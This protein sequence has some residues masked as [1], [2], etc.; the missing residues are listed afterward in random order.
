MFVRCN[1]SHLTLRRDKRRTPGEGSQGRIGAKVIVLDLESLWGAWV[2][3]SPESTPIA[4]SSSPDPVPMPLPLTSAT[5]DKAARVML[6]GVFGWK[7]SESA[8]IVFRLPKPDTR[9]AL[10]QLRAWMITDAIPVEGVDGACRRQGRGL[11]E[12]LSYE[13]PSNQ[14]LLVESMSDAAAGESLAAQEV[15]NLE[16]EVPKSRQGAAGGADS[17][18]GNLPPTLESAAFC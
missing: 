7:E 1:P 14:H 8:I 11:G 10:A 9:L 3:R 5:E 17:G 16:C 13:F 18:S 6:S 2:L 15:D 12:E 4:P